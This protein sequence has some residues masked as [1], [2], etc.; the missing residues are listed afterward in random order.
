MSKQFCNQVDQFCISP[1][2]A[3]PREFGIKSLCFA[4]GLPVCIECSSRRRYYNYGRV[5]LCNSCQFD[6]D[7]NDTVV[8]RRLYKQAG[9]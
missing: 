6:Y 7:G 4:C 2:M 5:R 3:D 9:Y 8:M 1:P